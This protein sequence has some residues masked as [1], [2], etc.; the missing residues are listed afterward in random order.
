MQVYYEKFNKAY[1]K[2]MT[3]LSAATQKYSARLP[4]YS[5]EY[6]GA[7]S[8]ATRQFID[9]MNDLKASYSDLTKQYW[10]GK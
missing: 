6:T 8:N 3:A 4:A 2:Y 9:D 10:V 7:V 1:S 5:N